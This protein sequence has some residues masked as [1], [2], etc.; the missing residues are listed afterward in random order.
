MMG[1]DASGRWSEFRN[2]GLANGSGERCAFFGLFHQ[3]GIGA[4]FAGECSAEGFGTGDAVGAGEH[5]R[6][7]YQFRIGLERAWDAR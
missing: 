5:H 1:A 7:A 2:S 6:F 3:E 4:T